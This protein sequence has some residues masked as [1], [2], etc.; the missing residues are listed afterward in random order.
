MMR[1]VVC[2]IACLAFFARTEAQS[3][4]LKDQQTIGLSSF[5]LFN[6]KCARC[7]EGECSKRMCL[8]SEPK[9]AADHIQRYAGKVSPLTIDE[10]YRQLSYMKQRCAYFP[11]SAPI[12]KDGAWQE[13]DLAAL[14]L[15]SRRGCFV[16]LGTLA[17]GTYSIQLSLNEVASFRIEIISQHFEMMLDEQVHHPDLQLDRTFTVEEA[18][19]HFLRLDSK[20]AITLKKLQL[21]K[22]YR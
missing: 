13:A 19:L 8:S 22:R 4:E 16:P 17:T 18:G 10:L 7:H 2:L 3:F 1:F 20:S 5:V 6:T 14:F 15:Q 12:P 11:V 21:K 9:Q